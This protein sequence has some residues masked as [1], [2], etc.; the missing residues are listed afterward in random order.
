[1]PGNRKRS[2]DETA[3]LGAR[4]MAELSQAREGQ[5]VIF[6]DSGA[7]RAPREWIY[8]LDPLLFPTQQGLYEPRSRWNHDPG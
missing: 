8:N 5:G 7:S 4:L 3:T 1:M 6:W 2:A